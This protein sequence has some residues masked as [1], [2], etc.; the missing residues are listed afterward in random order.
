[1]HHPLES[2]FDS[3]VDE[4][5]PGY[6]SRFHLG[7]LSC[8]PFYF[9]VTLPILACYLVWSSKP[10]GWVVVTLTSTE[11]ILVGIDTKLDCGISLL[12]E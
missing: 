4:L 10:E 6:L 3:V 7:N 9:H 12:L 11:M 2:C 8:K 1:M 5:Q